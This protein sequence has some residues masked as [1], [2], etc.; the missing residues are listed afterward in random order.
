ML[1]SLISLFLIS[2]FLVLPIFFYKKIT[3][4]IKLNCN[5]NPYGNIIKGE[6]FLIVNNILD[7]KCRNSIVNSFLEEA[8]HN[9]NLNE[10]K[11]LQF[12]SNEHFLYELSKLVGEKLYPVNS[13]DLQRCWLRYYFEG[14]KAQYYEN[15]HNDIKRY[16]STT[17]QYR[18]I[19]PVYDT[20]DSKF[21]IHDYGEFPFRQNMG[22]FLEADNCL[23]KVN[24]SKGE[25]LLLI[26]DFTTKDCDSL[27]NHYKCR[28]ISGYYN[29]IKDV[30]WRN[31]SSI[32][33]KISNI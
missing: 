27:Y 2:L 6:G 31:I 19:I 25:R 23:H 16:S 8:R 22:V 33:Y 4:D 13:L 20:S 30:I 18:L 3:D 21:T 1:L 17:K 28:G 12:Y 15:Y 11:K 10:D 32:Y 24:F 7:E 9:K 29:W 26:M 5:I 14:M